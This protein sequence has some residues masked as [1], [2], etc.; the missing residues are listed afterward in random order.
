MFSERLEAVVHC[1][2]STS[3]SLVSLDGFEIL[4]R[5]YL[6]S[7]DR[8]VGDQLGFGCH[9][10]QH[11]CSLVFTAIIGIQLMGVGGRVSFI[12]GRT[13]QVTAGQSSLEGDHW[14]KMDTNWRSRLL[15]V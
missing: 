12:R 14:S 1:L 8:M 6:V 3:L 5:F 9:N 2:H 15:R 11:N 10:Y 13:G 4:L 7:M